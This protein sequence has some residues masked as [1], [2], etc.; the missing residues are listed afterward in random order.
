MSDVSFLTPYWSGAEMMR[1][2][3][4][5]LRRFHPDAPILVSKRGGDDG[6]MAAWRREFGVDYQLEDCGY[7]DAYLRLLQRCQTQ[8][9]CMLDHDTV[10]LSGLDSLLDGLREG[11]YDLVGIEERIRLPEHVGFDPW[12]ESNGWLRF[13]PG[14]T[15]SNFLIFDWRAFE[16]R[17][18]LRGILGHAARGR[19]PLRFRLRHRPAPAAPPLPA[20][21]SHPEIRHREPVERRRPA[22]GVASMVRIVPDA[23]GGRSAPRSLPSPQPASARSSP[24]TRTWSWPIRRRPGGP[25]RDVAAEQLAI[26]VDRARRA[27]AARSSSPVE[28]LQSAHPGRSGAHAS[29]S[30]VAASLIFGSSQGPLDGMLLTGR[31]RIVATS[32]I[33][34]GMRSGD[35]PVSHAGDRA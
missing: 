25:E 23:P 17:W 16:S 2:H 7:T 19:A 11:R 31:S 28:P 34:A 33:L 13:A 21:V 35:A 14:C 26:A 32:A 1:I 15:A 3:L 6:E 12:P 10:L 4:A 24:T 22:G 27:A 29:R 5:S 8:Y 18:G 20:A 30:L 9:A